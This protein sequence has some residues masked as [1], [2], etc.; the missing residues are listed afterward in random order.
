MES[1]SFVTGLN[2]MQTDSR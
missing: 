2:V 1:A